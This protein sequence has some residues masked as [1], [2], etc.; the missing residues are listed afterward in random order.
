ES[1]PAAAEVFAQLDLGAVVGRLAGVGDLGVV[2]VGRELHRDLL[3]NPVD[4]EDVGVGDD[5]AVVPDRAEGQLVVGGVFRFERHDGGALLVEGHAARAIAA[6][7]GGAGAD[8]G[9]PVVGDA[10]RRQNGFK[11]IVAQ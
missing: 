11:R 1:G 8:V 7:H 2:D 5:F 9:R 6:G 10:G 4:V 3:V